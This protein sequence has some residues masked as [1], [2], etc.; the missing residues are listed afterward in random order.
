MSDSLWPL[1]CRTSGFPVLQYS[2]EFAQTHVHWVGWWCHPTISSS[3][4]SFSSC[5]Q[6]FPESGSFSV[7]Q[8][9]RSSDQS[10][11]ASAL[12]LP[13]NIQDWFPLGL[14][15]LV[16][17]HSQ[18]LSRIFSS[19]TVQNHRFFSAQPSFWSNSYLWTRPLEKPLLA[20][21]CLYFLICHL[22]L[23][24]LFFRGA[25][26]FSYKDTQAPASAGDM[27][28]IPGPGRSHI[29]WSN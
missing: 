6:S 22:G 8:L 27:S 3:V 25:S 21:W 13:M 14:T 26:I 1:D 17:L 11:G 20:K 4:A 19:T 5:P 29:L 28:S 23:S 18:G 16:S 12:V 15:G 7:S 24:L 2:L 10:T 9:F